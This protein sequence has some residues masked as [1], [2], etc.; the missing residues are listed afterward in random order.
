MLSNIA[1]HVEALAR[2][3]LKY[4]TLF[5]Q[6]AAELRKDPVRGKE[7]YDRVGSEWD[8]AAKPGQAWNI[9]DKGPEEYQKVMEDV[10][11]LKPVTLDE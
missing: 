2:K 9:G 6:H 3:R 4:I 10:C 5:E 11:S 8:L 7:A 1:P